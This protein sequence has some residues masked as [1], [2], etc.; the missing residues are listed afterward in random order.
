MN[1]LSHSRLIRTR[2]AGK[3]VGSARVR[4][5]GKSNR[6][7]FMTETVQGCL[8]ELGVEGCPAHP[9]KQKRAKKPKPTPAE[10]RAGECP[11][12]VVFGVTGHTDG[13]R[14]PIGVYNL[15]DALGVGPIFCEIQGFDGVVVVRDTRKR[16]GIQQAETLEG[17]FGPDKI[18][19]MWMERKK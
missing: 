2:D 12:C 5:V 8:C 4:V 10:I 3:N 9:Y 11:A 1:E 18:K 17:W 15:R 19:S 6:E 14:H 16:D 7:R 13:S